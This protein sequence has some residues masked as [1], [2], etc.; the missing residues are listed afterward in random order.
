METGASASGRD[1]PEGQPSK[2]NLVPR[3]RYC[4]QLASKDSAKAILE[5]AVGQMVDRG[6]NVKLMDAKYL[7]VSPKEMEV[8]TLEVNLLVHGRQPAYLNYV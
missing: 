5:Y 8:L 6:L 4:L 7:I 2:A 1:G 3:A